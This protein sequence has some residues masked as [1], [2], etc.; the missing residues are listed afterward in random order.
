MR[1]PRH[2]LAQRAVLH[3]MAGKDDVRAEVPVAAPARLT[4]F[5]RDRRIHGN[6]TAVQLAALHDSGELVSQNEWP[7]EPGVA[8]LALTE[9]VQVGAAEPD[10]RDADEALAVAG[11]RNRLAHKAYVTGCEETSDLLLTVR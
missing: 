1:R 6:A 11:H 5:A 2:V 8:D 10:R 7:G 4:P 9:P 3:A